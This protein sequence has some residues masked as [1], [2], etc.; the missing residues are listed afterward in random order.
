MSDEHL[1][2]EDLAGE[3]LHWGEYTREALKRG[4]PTWVDV[5]HATPIKGFAHIFG[6]PLTEH[7]LRGTWKER[8]IQAATIRPGLVLDLGCGAG[9][10]SLELARHGM[11]VHGIDI[12]PEQIAVASEWLNRMS[13]EEEGALQIKYEVADINSISLGR[14]RYVA[15][16]A[17]DALH[18]VVNLPIVFEEMSK[19][20]VPSGK[21]VA[22]EHIG[23]PFE[24]VRRI[25]AFLLRKKSSPCEDAGAHRLRDMFYRYFNVITEE[26][27]LCCAPFVAQLFQVYRLPFGKEPILRTLMA[28]DRLILKA[29]LLPGEY[30]YIEAIKV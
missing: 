2:Q 17:W 21:V 9:W 1:T 7:I 19:A 14:E 3:A 22:F 13:Q 23:G 30:M 16:V 24:Y 27:V 6:D 10:L 26:R 12:S 20:L 11:N 5:R 15:I 8:L 29:G 18:H 25:G 28:I 4:V